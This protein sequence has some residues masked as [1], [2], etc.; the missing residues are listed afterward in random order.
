VSQPETRY[1]RSGGIHVAFQVL[2]DGPVDLVFVPGFISNM[3]TQ[4]EDAGY[5]H[6]CH[7]LA[8][9]SRL[10]LFDKR[11]SGLSDRVGDMPDLETRMDDVR[12]VLDAAGRAGRC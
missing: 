2:G 7:R 3:E 1:A 6:L 11:G 9:F 8:A 5:A 4:W 12:A 10:I